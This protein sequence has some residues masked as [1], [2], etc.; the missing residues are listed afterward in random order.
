MR[1]SKAKLVETKKDIEYLLKYYR[2]RNKRL[3]AVY[4]RQL[5]HINNLINAL[6]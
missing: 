1:I 4:L 3:F 6:N 2:Y 5:Q